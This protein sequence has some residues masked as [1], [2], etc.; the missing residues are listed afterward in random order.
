[1]QKKELI[2][3]LGAGNMGTSIAQVVAANGYKVN[4]WNHSGDL[5]PLAQIREKKENINYLPGVK[6]SDNINPEP[7]IA[8]A[9]LGADVIF[10]T[11]PSNFFASVMKQVAQHIGKRAICVDVSKGMDEKTLD[12]TS[13]ILAKLLPKN[14]IAAISGPAIARQM[15]MGNFT[16]MNVA[17]TDARVIGVVKKIMESK[18]LKLL[19]TKD[20]VG[21]EV[22]GSFK[23]VY[24]I[25]MGICDSLSISTNT[26]A[27]L[28]V[29]ALQEMG[30]LVKKM[31]GKPETVAGLAG[32][33]DLL[34][35]G[36]AEGSRNRKLGEFL[37]QGMSLDEAAAKVG[38]VV[39]GV[40]A[41]RVLNSLSKKYKLKTPLADTISQIILGKVDPKTGIEHFLANLS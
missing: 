6:L 17:S 30:L 2:A 25:A 19:A 34:G 12:L 18:N 33:G 14:K 20:I 15:V 9:V 16:A 21:V 7:D 28:F 26:K 22:S 1:M 35:T 41:A 8:K 24:A 11:V 31:G 13:K 32:L 40:S 27:V 29:V 3:V 23:N 10:T 38:Q 5:E 36:L 37:A 4:L 39:E